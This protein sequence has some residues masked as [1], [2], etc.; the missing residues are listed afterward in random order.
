MLI[1]KFLANQKKK[2]LKYLRS[3]YAESLRRYLPDD[4]CIIS[5]NCLG[6]F[7]Y[8]DLGLSYTSPTAGLYF[9]FPDYIEF[10]ADLENNLKLDIEFVSHSKYQLG[11]ERL[12]NVKM[13]YP[14]GLLGGK[15]EIHFLH[16]TSREEAESKWKRRVERIN[17]NNFVIL[18]TEL[19]L[20][21]KTDIELFDKLPFTNKY[22]FTRSQTNLGSSV[23][24]EEFAYNAKIGDPYRYG[25]VLYANLIKK[26]SKEK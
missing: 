22:F 24:I 14:V 19:D 8:Q 16:Y 25:H 11:N 21:S 12:A 3:R 15:F 26:L 9:F 1:R 20:C 10:L 4:P 18:G 6:G 5:N 13:K 2:Y 23:F 7:I 17:P